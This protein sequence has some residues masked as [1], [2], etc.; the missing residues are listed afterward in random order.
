[1]KSEG[2]LSYNYIFYILLGIGL[3]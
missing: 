1:M 2:R 3:L